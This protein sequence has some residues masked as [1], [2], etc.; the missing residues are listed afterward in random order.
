MWF[1]N[2]NKAPRIAKEIKMMAIALIVSFETGM[3][4]TLWA[5]LHISRQN[6]SMRYSGVL[7]ASHLFRWSET[8]VTTRALLAHVNQLRLRN[9][10]ANQVGAIDHSTVRIFAQPRS[11]HEKKRQ[12]QTAAREKGPFEEP[13][14]LFR[15]LPTP[16]R[17]LP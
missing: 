17:S 8:A 7:R 15:Q 5:E 9:A 13:P 6:F 3:A 10:A 2:A 12:F 1:A 16:R 4:A 14:S 11:H